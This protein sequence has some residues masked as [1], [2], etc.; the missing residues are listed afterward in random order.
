MVFF[1]TNIFAQGT[2]NFIDQ[3]YIEVTGSA[4]KKITPNE[5]YIR[6]IIDEKDN[7]G[8]ISVEQQERA[9]MK[10]L[11]ASGIDVEKNLKMLDQGS[12]FKNYILKKNTILTTKEYQ[13]LVSTG[14]MAGEVFIH[15]EDIGISNISIDHV[16]HS[17]MEQFKRDV[18]I[19]AI[20]AAKEKAS[21]LASAIGQKAG[22]ALYIRENENYYPRYGATGMKMMANVAREDSAMETAADL[23]FEKITIEYTVQAYFELE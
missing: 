4:E 19:D 9:M 20:K 10:A 13:L 11:R 22:K 5:I 2:K 6:I 14:K 3:N 12:N 15:L 7:K 16:D 18:K 21:D 23:E 17:D 8:K 1:S